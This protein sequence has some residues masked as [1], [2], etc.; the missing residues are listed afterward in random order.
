MRNGLNSSI[1]PF[2]IND[3]IFCLLSRL[4]GSAIEHETIKTTLT[5]SK[6]LRMNHVLTSPKLLGKRARRLKNLKLTNFL[7]LITKD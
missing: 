1:T 3:I 5:I 6:T 2:S 4:S 7:T